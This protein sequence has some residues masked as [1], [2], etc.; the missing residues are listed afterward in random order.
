MADVFDKATRSKTMSAVKSK[1]NKST[2][3]RLIEFFKKF[4]LKGWRRGYKLYGKPD[5]V[6]LGHRTAIFAD[7]CFW[8]G[9][10]CR[11]LTPKDNGE[12]WSA[13]IA[14]NKAR[15]AEVTARL[16]SKNWRVIRLW[17]CEIKKEETLKEK[18]GEAL[19]NEKI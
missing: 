14:K 1:N 6:F 11:N 5:F 12:Y 4:G 10:D 9:H 16:L 8:H 13:K 2:E 19:G 17:E 18:L 3:K 15:D 7:G